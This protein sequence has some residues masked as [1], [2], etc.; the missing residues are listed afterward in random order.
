[1]LNLAVWVKSNAGQGQFYRSQHELIGIFRVGAERH[2]NNVEA[3]KHGRSRSNVWEYRGLNGFGASRMADLRAH[4]TIKPVAM[5]CD[6][7]KDC[8]RR[9]DT[10][11][12]TFIGSGTTIL[13]AERVGRRAVGVEI[14]PRFVD[15]AIRRWQQMTGKDAVHVDDG[16]TFLDLT[17]ER[18][19][20]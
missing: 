3:G 16:R 4:P 9:D 10:V 15:L 20:S 8:T 5:V 6:A 1:M 14:E 13:A 12:D 7:I 19:A 18:A 2:L 17:S 11:L